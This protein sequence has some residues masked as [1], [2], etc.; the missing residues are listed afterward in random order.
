MS[1][2]IFVLHYFYHYFIEKSSIYFPTKL[3]FGINKRGKRISITLCAIHN[4][5]PACIRIFLLLP[6]CFLLLKT[7]FLVSLLRF[8][9]LWFKTRRQNKCI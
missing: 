9:L 3:F 4:A 7:L 1:L 8:F 5:H 2:F 6:V